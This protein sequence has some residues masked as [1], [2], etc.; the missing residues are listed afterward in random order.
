MKILGQINLEGDK[1]ISHRA[2]ILA[3]LC[4]GESIIKNLS[5][6]DDVLS[7][8][9]CLGQTGINIE[10]NNHC[11]VINGDTFREPVSNLNC[12]NS[13]TSMRLLAGLYSSIKLP[14]TLEGDDS[15]SKRP[16]RRI[17][18]PLRDM[19]VI[20]DSNMNQAPIKLIDFNLKPI[21]H[22]ILVPSAQVKSCLIL[23]SINLPSKVV[24]QQDVQTRDHLELM[25][26]SLFGDII[27][28]RGKEI[29]VDGSEKNIKKF[30]MTIPGD[31]S[32]A[33]YLIALAILLKNSK[34]VINDILLNPLRLG[35]VNT[36][37]SMGANIKV[38]NINTINNEQ[39]GRITVKGNKKLS[40]CNITDDSISSMI[41]EIPILALV[42]S[43][44][45]GESIISGL[46][47]LRYKESD[48]LIGIYNILKTMGVSVNINNNSSL[49]I[50]RGKNLYNTNNLDNLNDHRLAMVISCA[51]IVQGKKI[52]FD[53]CIKVSFPNFKELVETI[54][55]N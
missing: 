15:L 13:G 33:S 11:A 49:A 8:I 4:R 19:G 30:N 50:K 34:L 18:D 7:T 12:N 20:L 37:I 31:I 16:M 45:D 28:T 43:Y 24:I 17:L 14:V 21:N 51:Q 44:I 46:D 39:V 1:S 26:N 40:P 55:V 41:D 53:D 5:S 10:F 29:I 22:K 32:S 42:C 47:E 38:D 9:S 6:S 23:S 3:S 2:L 36:L 35:F 54:L 52:D 27:E 48:R 25:I